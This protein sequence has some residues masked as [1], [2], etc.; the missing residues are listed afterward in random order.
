MVVLGA[1]ASPPSPG[2]ATARTCT[3]DSFSAKCEAIFTAA[4][5]ICLTN[6]CILLLEGS[7]EYSKEPGIQI[8]FTLTLMLGA[9]GQTLVN[10]ARTY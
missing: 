2:S 5:D 7:S 8:Y 6:I 3:F 10:L 4:P 1:L 9:E